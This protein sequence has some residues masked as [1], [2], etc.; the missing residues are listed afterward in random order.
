[1]RSYIE[2][3]TFSYPEEMTFSFKC[4]NDTLYLDFSINGDGTWD[5]YIAHTT[6]WRDNK[7]PGAIF[8]EN[9]T[10]YLEGLE[11]F[12]KYWHDY[13]NYWDWE[14]IDLSEAV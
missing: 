1:M 10:V 2:P 9:N 7:W 14:P 4:G 8:T 13:L 3:Q 6:K 12:F 11:Q 5:T